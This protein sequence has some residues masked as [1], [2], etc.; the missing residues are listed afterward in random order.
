[1]KI[2][3][4]ADPELPVPPKLYGGIERI[5]DSLVRGLKRR[6]H[7]IGLVAHRDS[8]SPVDILFPW[9]GLISQNKIDMVKNTV[10]LFASV[11][12]FKP[13]VIHSFSRLFY[14]SPFFLSSIPKLMSYQRYPTL[15]TVH[16]ATKLSKGSLHFTGLSDF[17]CKIGEKA[18]GIWHRIYNFVDLE[19]YTFAP[20]VS[21]DAPLVF[22]SRVERIKGAHT[23][24]Q[25]AKKTG[26]R[27][28]IA[29][30]HGEK[31]N[32]G[33][34]WKEEIL[35]HLDKDGIEY[36]GPVDDTQK[37]ILLGKALAMIVPIEWEEP[38]GIVFAESLA[39]GTPVISCPR[40]A[41]PE[42]VRNGI[43]GFLVNNIDEAISKVKNLNRIDRH[44]CRARVEQCFSAK[45][46]VEQYENL[47]TTLMKSNQNKG[48]RKIQ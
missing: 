30:N 28:L 32:D 34:Y 22:L 43:E 46:V 2:L 9:P 38:F 40:G 39:C 7:I 19:K 24:I 26:R 25:I 35:P 44:K 48:E 4:T 33:K 27:L 3:L 5:V 45:V 14:L 37:N 12:K 13:D 1:M 8:T 36:V 42:I 18:G 15:R 31:G 6:G 17:I 21:T 47:Y 23:A 10:S 20:S 29:G 11:K 16:L 41:L